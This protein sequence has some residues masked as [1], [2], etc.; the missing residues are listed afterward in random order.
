MH[1]LATFILTQSVVAAQQ[2]TLEESPHMLPRSSRPNPIQL[3]AELT[4]CGYRG[5][6]QLP[7]NWQESTWFL[8]S[9]LLARAFCWSHPF[10]MSPPCLLLEEGSAW[11]RKIGW[12]S[13]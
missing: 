5:E 3:I 4:S 8:D 11:L 1:R 10:W 9:S 2:L 13:Y 6:R 12:D 7:A